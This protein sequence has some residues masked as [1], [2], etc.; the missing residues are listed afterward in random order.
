MLQHKGQLQEYLVAQDQYTQQNP[1]KNHYS[2][3]MMLIQNSTT[4]TTVTNNFAQIMIHETKT[5][6]TRGQMLP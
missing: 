6:H 2:R 1:N 3:S 5:I 4:N